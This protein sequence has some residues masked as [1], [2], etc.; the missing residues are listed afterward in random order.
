MYRALIYGV[1][2][3]IPNGAKRQPKISGEDDD[4]DDCTWSWLDDN[5]SVAFRPKK[6]RAENFRANFRANL[7]G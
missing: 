1:L 4:H 6:I 5:D 3:D 2:G 7:A